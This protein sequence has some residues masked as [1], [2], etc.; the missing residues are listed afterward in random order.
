MLSYGLLRTLTCKRRHWS[1]GICVPD[2]AQA[3]APV[4]MCLCSSYASSV[5]L[6]E[7]EQQAAEDLE[8]LRSKAGTR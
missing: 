6:S 3:C 8:Y 2:T 1:T 7:A 5:V 4:R